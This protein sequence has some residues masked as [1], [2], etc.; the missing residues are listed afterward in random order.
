MRGIAMSEYVLQVGQEGFDRLKFINDVFGEHSRNFVI[1]AGLRQG[2]RVL[3][4]GCGTGSMTTWLAEIV[5]QEGTVLA[6]DASQSQIDLARRA[7]EN[8]GARNVEFVCSPVEA[9][10]LPD[11]SI[12]LAYSRLLLMHLKNPMRVL[13]SVWKLLKQGG[14][15]ACEEPHSS[16]LTTA[17]RNESIQRL[18]DLFIELGNLQGID[19]NIGDRLLSLLRLAGYS[20]LHA[21]FIQPVISMAEAAEFIRMGAVEIAPF[22]VKCGIVS[23]AE[24]QR[25]LLEMESCKFDADSIYTFP[26][27]AQVFGYK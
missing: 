14:V 24:T 15:I 25:V 22:A 1:R 27:Q 12:N 26:R 5:G 16:S 13:T 18:N 9:L 8:A 6:V 11:G 17:P 3:E 7:V 2:D 19:F 23:E 20:D 10:E 4:L 21:C